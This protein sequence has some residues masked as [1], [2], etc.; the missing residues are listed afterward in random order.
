MT[1][2]THHE[3]I[4]L[5]E[6]FARAGLQ[7]DL[8]RSDRMAR[9]LMFRVRAH[10]TPPPAARG[11]EGSVC[12]ADRADRATLELDHPGAGHFRLT[13]TLV[14]EQDHDA[15]LQVEGDDPA[16]LLAAVEAVPLA[17]Q[18]RDGPGYTMASNHRIDAAGVLR[19]VS[20]SVRVGGMTMRLTASTVGTRR[21]DVVLSTAPGDPIDLPDDLLA[22]LGWDWSRLDRWTHASGSRWT[23]S[24]RLG[25]S[26]DD[27]AE[28]RLEEAARH[29]ARTLAEPPARFHERLIAARW[30]FAVRRA[31]PIGVCIALILGTLVFAR[32]GVSDESVLRMLVFNAPPLL[33]VAFFCLRDVPRIELP[34]R[35]RRLDAPAWRVA[36]PGSGVEA[37][38]VVEV[39]DVPAARR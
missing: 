16:V 15:T 11:M 19:L 14:V 31:I 21:A 8:A 18:V 39:P 7:V 30:R 28:R 27:D 37:P 23:G 5:V 29:L 38:P 13:R 22:V 26:I 1:P 36:P 2:L 20:G 25:R 33:L 10:G 17:R 24:V 9:R 4:G 6:P 35:P 32:V 12:C 3:I 34:R